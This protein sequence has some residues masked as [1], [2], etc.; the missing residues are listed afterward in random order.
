MS[1]RLLL[2]FRTIQSNRIPSHIRQVSHPPSSNPD[3]HSS[4]FLIEPTQHRTATACH[5]Q[6]A[7]ACRPA[8]MSLN[9]HGVS[10]SPPSHLSQVPLAYVA[11]LVVA[12]SSGGRTFPP[13]EANT[14]QQAPDRRLC[15]TAGLHCADC[16]E[17][18]LPFSTICCHV[19]GEPM[20]SA[21]LAHL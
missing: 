19:S 3:H 5:L 11:T 12:L 8:T 14:Q 13:A 9:C 6:R 17:I 1:A 20:S 7:Y 15:I 10:E 16:P 4:P 21:S 2:T 18:Y